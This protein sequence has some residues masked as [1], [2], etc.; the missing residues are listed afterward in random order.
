[1]IRNIVFVVLT[2]CGYAVDVHAW[3]LRPPIGRREFG[4]L[5]KDLPP[6]VD[7][8]NSSQADAMSTSPRQIHDL[9]IVGAGSLGGLVAQQWI[10]RH[11]HATV[12][13]ET[14][15]TAR[16]DI[17]RQIG[18]IPRLRECRSPADIHSASHVLIC[19]P[20]SAAPPGQL[21]P[22]LEAACSLL[23]SSNSTADF[24]PRG[25]VLYTSSTAVYG[26]KIEGDV[27]EQ[28]ELDLSSARASR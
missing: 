19:I 13:A 9:W 10:R 4:T 3:I 7:H 25:L 24:S 6:H 15:T 12:I 20:P 8:A 26:D 28:S 23:V 1:M 27:N 14:A 5:E 2:V 18:A 21:A 22:E 11:P 17:L 16:H